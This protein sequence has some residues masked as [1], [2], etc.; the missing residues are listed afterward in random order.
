MA[1]PNQIAAAKQIIAEFTDECR[2]N[3]LLAFPQS[4]KTQTFLYVA[5]NMLCTDAKID[6]AVIVCG[7]AEHELSEQ[8]RASKTE[9]IG[10]YVRTE[11][12][13]MSADI[14][15]SVIRN[16]P[17]PAP[18]GDPFTQSAMC[19]NTF[20]VYQELLKAE[21]CNRHEGSQDATQSKTLG[22]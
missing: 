20:A 7:N 12:P 13:N 3:V 2:W 16:S 9:F 15:Q 10:I 11:Y 14:T 6:R 8:L 22:A 19:R 1:Y 17:V 4:G 21:R 18:V 5:C